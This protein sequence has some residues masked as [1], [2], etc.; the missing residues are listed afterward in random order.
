[1]LKQ[2]KVDEPAATGEPDRG[3]YPDDGDIATPVP[4]L[5]CAPF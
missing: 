4:R 3:F 2:M 1:L 5:G